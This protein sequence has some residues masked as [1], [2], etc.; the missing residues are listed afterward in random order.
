MVDKMIS[1]I[2]DRWRDTVVPMLWSLFFAGALLGLSHRID[3]AVS[4]GVIGLD[5]SVKASVRSDLGSILPVRLRVFDSWAESLPASLEGGDVASARAVMDYFRHDGGARFILG[6]PL[7]SRL[8]IWA[9][10]IESRL[11]LDF[12][13]V[14][15]LVALISLSVAVFLRKDRRLWRSLA[16]FAS[17]ALVAS[18]CI[19]ALL[20]IVESIGEVWLTGSA[21]SRLTSLPVT[22]SLWT[23]VLSSSALASAVLDL[24]VVYC[25][26]SVLS[27]IYP[28]P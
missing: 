19:R 3:A 18:V 16:Y 8:I 2:L 17:R 27:L 14:A 10:E 25:L 6:S 15:S 9:G 5:E 22:V 21:A 13:A 28:D 26:S 11:R 1:A 24:L 20:C 4:N 23:T 12:V 7:A